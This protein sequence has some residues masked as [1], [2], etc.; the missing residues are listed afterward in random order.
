MRKETDHLEGVLLH[1]AK[2]AGASWTA[3][4]AVLGVSRQAVHKKY[5]SSRFSRR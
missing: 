3:I 1:R 4:A 5:G 2:L